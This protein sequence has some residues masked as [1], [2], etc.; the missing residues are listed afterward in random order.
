MVS[1]RTIFYSLLATIALSSVFYNDVSAQAKHSNVVSVNKKQ[2]TKKHKVR[3]QNHMTLPKKQVLFKETDPATGKVYS[4]MI[5]PITGTIKSVSPYNGMGGGY[6]RLQKPLNNWGKM[7]AKLVAKGVS[8]ETIR[9]IFYAD[10]YLDG[11]NMIK[12]GYYSHGKA[13]DYSLAMQKS[14]NADNR[15]SING[16]LSSYKSSMNKY[17]NF[18]KLEAQHLIKYNK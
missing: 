8:T 13:S 5:T 18:Q 17:H 11:V 3:K 2:S 12:D 16:Y 4:R 1:K 9:N 15:S 6:N 14:F 7:L 10:D